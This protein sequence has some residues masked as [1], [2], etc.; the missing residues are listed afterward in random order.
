MW[1][2]LVVCLALF[3]AGIVLA[4]AT[5]ASAE[6]L[7]QVVSSDGVWARWAPHQGDVVGYGPAGGSMVTYDCWNWGDAVGPYNNRLWYWVDWSGGFTWIND[8]WLSDP[9]PANTPVPG[10]SQCS[11]W[12]FDAEVSSNAGYANVRT[13]PTAADAMGCGVVQ[14]D[15]NRSE[16]SAKCWIDSG[17]AYGGQAGLPPSWSNRWFAVESGLGGEPAYL[18]V[19][20]NLVQNPQ[21]RLPRCDAA[22][23]NQF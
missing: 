14:E 20:S 2:R 13:C 9:E 12:D 19:F 7:Y 6:A 3:T 23:L 8:H 5:P 17:W 22:L 18:Y 16:L 11:W 10:V 4:C 15:A 21:P 1:Q